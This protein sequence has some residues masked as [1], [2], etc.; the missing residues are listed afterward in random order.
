MKAAAL[1][2]PPS[3]GSSQAL[4]LLAVLALAGTARCCMR[5]ARAEA[6]AEA[7]RALVQTLQLTDLAWFTEA[8]YTR[9]LSQADLH[10]AF[11]DGPGGAGALSGRHAGG[12]GAAGAGRGL[13]AR[14]AVAPWQAGWR[15]NATWWTLP[16]PGCAASARVMPA[17]CW[18][19]PCWSSCWPRW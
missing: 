17:C 5:R 1:P 8:R 4:L 9:H 11:Q 14:R 16:W 3:R 2:P 13:C 12:P 6:R 10:T 19:T 18:C 7:S 15:V